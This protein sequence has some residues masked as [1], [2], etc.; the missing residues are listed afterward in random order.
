M[1][2]FVAEQNL[3]LSLYYLFPITFFLMPNTFSH[4]YLSTLVN[5]KNFK[6]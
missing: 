5:I 6:P 1:S 2:V 3:T 4:L